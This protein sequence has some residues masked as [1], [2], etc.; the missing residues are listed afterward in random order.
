MFRPRLTFEH[1]QVRLG[2]APVPGI[3]K[4]HRIRS[5]VRFD[6]AEQDGLSGK[7]KIPM[8]WEDADIQLTVE[9]LTDDK[10]SCYD[11]LA[12]LNGIF[13]GVDSKGNPLVLAVE[14]VH[15]MARGVRRV[16]FAGLDSDESDQDDVITANL[17]FVEHVP[18]VTRVENRVT[19]AGAA[20]DSAPAV[21]T[22]EHELAPALLVGLE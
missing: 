10:D 21:K 3:L 12:A 1:G 14:N 18:A 9:L 15:C 16:V 2:D 11:K 17:H 19:A 13:R 7:A 5:A 20:G 6:E 4:R 22:A 8:G